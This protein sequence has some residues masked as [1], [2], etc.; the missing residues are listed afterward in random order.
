ML[1]RVDERVT[2]RSWLFLDITAIDYTEARGSVPVSQRCRKL[3]YQ[4]RS[5]ARLAR[6]VQCGPQA[7][8][9]I[10][11]KVIGVTASVIGM[12]Q[13]RLCDMA[14]S[15]IVFTVSRDTAREGCTINGGL[16]GCLKWKST[17]LIWN[18]GRE[19]EAGLILC[20]FSV[21]PKLAYLFGRAIVRIT[22]DFLKQ[23]QLFHIP[24]ACLINCSTY[25][26]HHGSL[27]RADPLNTPKQLQG[28]CI[29]C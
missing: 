25:R 2:S 23:T 28:Q 16:V 13:P 24:A 7:K 29:T 20:C 6:Q 12:L 5:G 27:V 21:Y 11:R 18:R 19:R 26:L 9:A 3:Q 14:M 22:K 8:A 4:P 15:A 17:V 10:P 1:K